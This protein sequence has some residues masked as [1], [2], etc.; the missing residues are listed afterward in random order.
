MFRTC[1]PAG[2]DFLQLL[3]ARRKHRPSGRFAKRRVSDVYRQ[4]ACRNQRIDLLARRTPR[5][6]SKSASS[7]TAWRQIKLSEIGQVQNGHG[8]ERRERSNFTA[9]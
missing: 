9:S 8:E 4:H 7:E 3:L 5:E 2:N 6:A 1:G